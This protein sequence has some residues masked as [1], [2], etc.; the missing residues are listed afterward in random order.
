MHKESISSLRFR[1]SG[2]SRILVNRFKYPLHEEEFSAVDQLQPENMK[3][4]GSVAAY[5]L[6]L[7]RA[8]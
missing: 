4:D 5:D 7:H 3:V 1:V 8:L 6:L 2:K